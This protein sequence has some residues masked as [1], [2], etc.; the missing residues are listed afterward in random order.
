MPPF[1]RRRGRGVAGRAG[2]G[3]GGGAG[4][5]GRPR[6]G[7]D[8]QLGKH[9]P[10]QTRKIPPKL[11][12][13]PKACGVTHLEI[14]L[15]Y[16]NSRSEDVR[17]RVAAWLAAHHAVI[18]RPQALA[19]GLTRAQV[20]RLVSSGEWQGVHAGVYRLAGAP[21]TSLDTLQAA[22]LAGGSGAVASHQSAAWLW[23]IRDQPPDPPT[24]TVPH[25]RVARIGGV[26]MIRSR[27]PVQTITRKGIPATSVSRTILDC[28]QVLAPDELDLLVDTALARRAITVE[29]LHK[30]VLSPKL[31]FYPGRLL[32]AQRLAARGIAGSPHP[33][34][35]ESRTAR[36]MRR[37]RIPVPKA[38]LC[39]GPH[40][41]Y[42]LDFAYPEL[43][44]VV[45]VD[46]WVAHLTPEKQ[47]SDNR[48]DNALNRAGWTVLHYDWWEVTYDADRVAGEIADT[49]RRLAAAA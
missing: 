6:T 11:L 40:Q 13:A 36:L 38:E 16:M 9:P 1:C 10:G 17:R 25:H 43:R 7:C 49:Y 32:L 18:S 3:A 12:I 8:R 22:V 42:R 14:Y 5:K 27:R 28:A 29:G 47:R 4:A 48:R 35:L 30:T 15:N 26:R 2:G 46:G 37:H 33:S 21:C 19:L 34:V 20:D 45:E 31:R 41:R 44:L 39:W 23:E 24:I